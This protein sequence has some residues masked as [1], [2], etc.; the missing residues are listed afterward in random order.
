MICLSI[1]SQFSVSRLIRY[2]CERNACFLYLPGGRSICLYMRAAGRLMTHR[3]AASIGM[4]MMFC[5]ALVGALAV[6]CAA[7]KH[8][9]LLRAAFCAR[10]WRAARAL[11]VA[12]LLHVL[13]AR[14]HGATTAAAAALRGKHAAARATSRGARALRAA[15]ARA[16][17]ARQP[18]SSLPLL[19]YLTHIT[20]AT[21]SQPP[22]LPVKQH[23]PVA[24][25]AWRAGAACRHL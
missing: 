8:C 4:G 10:A 19:L 21:S 25:A 5:R 22:H 15:A 17:A 18:P 12:W 23:L 14:R 16:A 6:L 20:P 13:S 3:Q 2:L 7:C 11:G 1:H 9:I 24:A